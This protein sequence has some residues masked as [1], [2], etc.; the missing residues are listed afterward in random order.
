MKFSAANL[1]KI[2]KYL[3]VLAL[4]SSNLIP[5]QKLLSVGYDIGW[6]HGVL[7]K[8]NADKFLKEN[9]LALDYIDNFMKPLLDEDIDY[10]KHPR[11]FESIDVQ[12]IDMCNYFEK[13][14][15]YSRA[16]FLR[17]YFSIED[18][19]EE[20]KNLLNN[21][22][23]DLKKQHEMGVRYFKTSY[24]IMQFLKEF[25]FKVDHLLTTFE[26][27]SQSLLQDNVKL[28]KA[29]TNLA[30]IEYQFLNL[31]AIMVLDIIAII[32]ILRHT[33]RMLYFYFVSV[34]IVQ[35]ISIWLKW[36]L[37]HVAIAKDLVQYNMDK[38]KII[39]GFEKPQLM[40]HILLM[41]GL[42]IS[43]N[44]TE[45]SL[46]YLSQ[47]LWLADTETQRIPEPILAVTITKEEK[48]MAEIFERFQCP[49]CFELMKG[50]LQ[51]YS[52]SNDH[53]ICSTCLNKPIMICPICRDDFKNQK[54][55]RRF[56]SEQLL[57]NLLDS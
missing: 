36:Y 5:T 11:M 3:I 27:K 54:P 38:A 18:D 20:F 39:F 40:L 55:T 23:Q 7:W 9:R 47:Y 2:L 33:K 57:S 26:Q 32:V 30:I 45:K 22:P 56:T 13:I 25:C 46:R 35:L 14:A 16:I 21:A 24:A 15:D 4:V 48:K 44:D 29:D 53:F 17:G 8:R 19:D 34:L 6:L 10:R 1:R 52:C 49:V 31:S 42:L 12:L 50:P 51:I 37:L 43:M 41:L 28:D